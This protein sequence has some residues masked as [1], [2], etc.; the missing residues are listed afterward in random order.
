V[1]PSTLRV[2]VAPGLTTAISA[3]ATAAA[4]RETGGVLLGWWN[5]EAVVVRHTVEVSDPS[6]TSVAWT[7]H[8]EPA[9]LAL[10]DALREL[11]HPW[12]GYVGDWHTHPAPCDAS[13]QDLESIRRASRQYDHPLVLLIHR[14]NGTLD[15]RAALRGRLRA[16]T[17][18]P[19]EPPEMEQTP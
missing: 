12:L 18:I 19:D 6:A 1:K 17:I 15:L 10:D 3:A 8:E 2:V 7:R 5:T 13:R 14:P 11:E 9:Q 4:P 16:A